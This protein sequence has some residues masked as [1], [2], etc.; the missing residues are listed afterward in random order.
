MATFVD[1]E[2]ISE[3]DL[4]PKDIEE[5]SRDEAD[6]TASQH[7]DNISIQSAESGVKVIQTQPVQ[8]TVVQSKEPEGVMSSTAPA[9][10]STGT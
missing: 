8:S 9:R 2:R 10:L 3:E 5:T 4:K 7:D 1:D 6:A